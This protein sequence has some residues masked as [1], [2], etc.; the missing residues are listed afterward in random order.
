MTR[1]RLV[2]LTISLVVVLSFAGLLLAAKG[3]G[4]ELFRALGNLAEVV[5]LVE[6]EYVDELN[7]EA[8]VLSLDAGIVES[9]DPWAAVVPTDRAAEW[10]AAFEAPPAFGLVL[11]SR[12]GSAAVRAVLDG[13][14]ADDAGLETWE[15]IEQV[16]GVYTRGRPMWQIRLELAARERDGEDVLLTVVDRQVDARRDVTLRARPWSPSPVDVQM[17]DDVQIVRLRGLPRGAAGAL[18]EA[19]DPDLAVVLDLR[20]LVWG[21]D[22]EAVAV[23]DLFASEGVLAEWSGRRAGSRTY[24]ATAD[25]GDRS[26]PVVVIGPETEGPGEIL[27]GALQRAGAVTVGRATVG[28]APYMQFVSTGDLALWIPVG[29]WQRPDGEAIHRTGVEPDEVIEVDGD[30]DADE[31]APD[32]ALERAIELATPSA[33]GDAAQAA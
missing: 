7:R 27:A 19:L 28:H 32:R 25:E 2:F 22:T 11:T 33:A 16:D 18:A 24:T 29:R 12:L 13:S 15:V 30:A 20:E 26:V 31:E 10:E 4:E 9:I 14:P 23:A 6:T 8:L 21:Q 1:L 17:R 5:H 3:E